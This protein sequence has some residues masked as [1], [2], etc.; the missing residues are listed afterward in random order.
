MYL[1]AA[2]VCACL[3]LTGVSAPAAGAAAP[4]WRVSVTSFPT[5]LP[6]E[7]NLNEG[8]LPAYVVTL[9][10]VGSGSSSG[11]IT[12][13]DTL[14]VGITQHGSGDQVVTLE[15]ASF[16]GGTTKD[17]RPGETATAVIEVDVALPEGSTVTDTVTVSGGGAPPAQ[18]STQSTVSADAANFDFLPG[19]VGLAGSLTDSDGGAVTQAGSHPFQ[20]SFE[21]GL[22]SKQIGSQAG[23][24]ELL[25]I[26][27]GLRDQTTIF[28]KGLVVNPEATP[29][30]CTEAQFEGLNCP[31]ASVVGIAHVTID[32]LSNGSPGPV[33]TPVYNMVPPVGKAAHFALAPEGLGI[34]VHAFG[35]VRPGDYALQSVTTDN[36]SLFFSQVFAARIQ[37]WGDPSSPLYDA[38]RGKCRTGNVGTC[39]VPKRSTPFLSLPSACQDSLGLEAEASSWG[40]PDVLHRRAEALTDSSGNP[41][42]V[43]GCSALEFGPTLQARPTTTVAD[44]PSGLSVDLAIPQS[45]DVNQLDTAQ[46]RKAVVAL[47]IGMTLNP[48]SANGLGSCTSGQIGIDPGTGVADGEPVACPDNSQ[49]GTV[50]VDTPLLSDPLSGSVYVAKPYDNPFNSLLAIYVTVEDPKSGVLVKLAGH[51]VA[52]PASGRLTTTFDEN[53]Q[54]PF[55]HFKLTFK[56]GPHGTFRTPSTCGPYST[57]SEMTPWSA[58]DSGPPATPHDDYAIT[59]GPGGACA[60]SQAALPNAPSFDAGSASAVAGRHAPFVLHLRRNDGTQNFSAVT[61][62]PPAGL[63]AKLAGTQQC[64][65]AAL[66]V[67][68]QKSGRQEQA[69]PSCP[70]ASEVGSLVAGVGAGPAP[71]YAPGKAYLTGPYKGAPLGV[72]FIT[73]A[74]AGPYDLGTIVS[75]AAIHVDPETGRDTTVSDPLPTILQGI[76]LDVRSIDISFDR[77]DFTVNGTSCDPL[78]VD[79]QLTSTLGQIAP[80]SQRFQLAECSRL[81]FKPKLGIR[82]TGGTKRGAHPALKGTLTMPVGG[83]NIARASVALPHSEFLDQAHIGTVCT[84]VQFAADACPAASVYGHAMALSPL[85]DYPLEGPVYLR[86]SSHKLPDL[87]LALRGP[88]SQPVEVDAVGRVDSVKGGIRTTFEGVPDLPVSKV[89]LSMA[90]A[91]K[92]LLQNSTNAC[93]ANFKATAEFDG[94]NGKIA[95]L[96]PVLRNSK[97]GKAGGHGKHRRASR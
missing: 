4:A 44:S 92:G 19:T 86:S 17:F 36:L 48:S 69:S 62:S 52:D 3:S 80:L 53:P 88:A 89:V 90:G 64:P 71:F 58:P 6:P 34:F 29:V 25:G 45:D 76:V 81:A 32:I 54:L 28:P 91:K 47:P 63:A 35:E 50:E 23:A 1:I 2:A 16:F 18:A 85:V 5:N 14:P 20:F 7:Y 11:P 57:T 10:N 79:G 30:K 31:D 22:P 33:G 59:Q 96:S 95:D 41:T 42:G 15:S 93:R 70:A 49:I 8:S 77:P 51:A 74:V 21:F 68:A 73:P 83:A 78:S 56:G 94:Q 37:L 84:R 55:D 66:A 72:A 65:D 12:V 27:G 87:V 13:T 26:D 67:A 24:G 40:H 61:V 39:P 82:L 46:L 43:T 60:T 75:R 9:A 38:V 97:C